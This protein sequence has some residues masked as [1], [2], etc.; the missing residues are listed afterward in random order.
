M[1]K[2]EIA[3]K[4]FYFPENRSE[5]SL[6]ESL[7]LSDFLFKKSHYSIEEKALEYLK[8][9]FQEGNILK[10]N[11]IQLAQL[12]PFAI[13]I[14]EIPEDE[15]IRP[16]FKSFSRW[17]RSFYL[18]KREI[19][20]APAPNL[21]TSV[22]AEFIVADAYCQQI[23]EEPRKLDLLMACLYRKKDSKKKHGDLRVKFDTDDLEAR[24]SKFKNVHYAIKL[25][26]FHFFVAVKKRIAENY[27]E[28]FVSDDDPNAVKGDWTETL[29]QIAENKVFGEMEKVKYTNLYE[30]LDYQI[31]KK[32][33]NKTVANR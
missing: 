6:K 33:Q 10:L 8:F 19:Y 13:K 31:M 18:A 30:V 9:S 15:D 12:V 16:L 20:Y 23:P 32:R 7:F 22:V 4:T 1:H 28:L 29:L 14:I 17:Q 25:Q 26:C 5:I 2:I 3:K 24:A 11:D 27:E 21:E